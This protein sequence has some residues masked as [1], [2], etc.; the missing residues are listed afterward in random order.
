M[1]KSVGT[2]LVAGLDG[3]GHRRREEAVRHQQAANVSDG[4]TDSGGQFLSWSD[5]LE[6]FKSLQHRRGDSQAPKKSG[7]TDLVA[8]LDGS[9]HRRCEE[10]V[11]DQ[12]LVQR[13]S[14]HLHTHGR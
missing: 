6:G 5:V 12:H 4:V 8:R 2:H 14:C 3:R 10:P 13:L 1:G 7:E 9:G 11:R